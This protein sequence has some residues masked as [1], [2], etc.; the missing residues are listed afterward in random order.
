MSIQSVG[1]Y[2]E[3]RLFCYELCELLLFSDRPRWCLEASFACTRVEQYRA[4]GR[5]E[6]PPIRT[7]A[8]WETMSFIVWR[9][10]HSVDKTPAEQSH[11]RTKAGAL[12]TNRLSSLLANAPAA[13]APARHAQAR[14]R[15][16]ALSARKKWPQRLAK[17]GPRGD[18]TRA[19]VFNGP[20]AAHGEIDVSARNGTAELRSMSRGQP[21]CTALVCLARCL[22]GLVHP[23]PADPGV[24]T[25]EWPWP[26]VR[27]GFL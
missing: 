15:R 1:G 12:A 23:S 26:C 24:R 3:S 6:C 7:Q 20:T 18:Q 14:P 10:S 4:C 25:H 9:R 16:T 22:S 27:Q 17:S 11:P 13:P 2:Y 19:Q 21:Y 5:R 8:R